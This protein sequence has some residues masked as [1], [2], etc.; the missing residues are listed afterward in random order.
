MMSS[1]K[2]EWI[3]EKFYNSTEDPM[4]SILDV[5][6]FTEKLNPSNL[7]NDEK[8][9]K[10]YTLVFLKSSYGEDIRD[11]EAIFKYVSGFYI[12]LYRTMDTEKFKL[13]IIYKPQHYEEIKLYINGLKKLK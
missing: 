12:Y 5:D 2:S 10:R 13:R 9:Q 8:L 6:F 3:F 1:D 7:I 4:M 11:Y